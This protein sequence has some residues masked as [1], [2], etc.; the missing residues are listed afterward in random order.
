[1]HAVIVTVDETT[2]KATAIKR[3]VVAGTSE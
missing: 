3:F 2:G 1:M